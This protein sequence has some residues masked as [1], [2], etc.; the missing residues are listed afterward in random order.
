MLSNTLRV[1][2]NKLELITDT[3]FKKRLGSFGHMRMSDT[4]LLKQLVK[5]HL[6]LKNIRED[7]KEIGL[8]PEDT[9]N[10]PKL[11]TSLKILLFLPYKKKNPNKNII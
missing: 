3:M 1:V 4:R 8:T 2:Y 6:F 10:K 7:L 11:T 5:Y 9:I